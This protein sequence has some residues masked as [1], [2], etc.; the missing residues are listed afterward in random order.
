L[1]KKIAPSKTQ[2]QPYQNPLRVRQDETFIQVY[3]SSEWKTIWKKHRPTLWLLHYIALKARRTDEAMK[4]G[5]LKGQAMIGDLKDMGLTNQEYK[6]ALKNLKK[7]N[8][9]TTKPTNKGTTVTLNLSGLYNINMETPYQQDKHHLTISQLTSPKK[10]TTNNNVY[11]KEK[12]G[13]GFRVVSLEKKI[14]RLLKE[15]DRLLPIKNK[16]QEN[17][18]VFKVTEEKIQK[19]EQALEKELGLE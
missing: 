12:K 14:D 4:G 10:P 11:N 13:N 17:L 15:R 16:T 19:C 7:W 5:L 8:F 18:K 1:S 3:R 2:I 6:T 9:L